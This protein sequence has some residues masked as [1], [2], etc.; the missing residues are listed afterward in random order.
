MKLSCLQ[1]NLSRGL[2]IV[3]RA[4]A[5]RTTLPITNNVYL[6][7]E[8]GRLKLAATNLEIA[9]VHW[10]GAKI[11]KEGAITVPARLLT[12][13]VN[14]LPNDKVEMDLS[15]KSKS[16]QLKCAKFEARFSGMDAEDFPPIPTIDQ[17]VTMKI[18]AEHLRTAIGRV[19]FAAATEDSRPV[20]TGVNLE[21][22][23][24]MLTLAAADG[25]RLSVDKTKVSTPVK[26]KLSVIVPAR[27]LNEVGKLIA[28]AKDPVT[29]TVNAAKSQILFSMEN[30]RLVSQ[31]IQ[32]AFPNYSQLIPQKH[33]TRVT[34]DLEE[35]LRATKAAS[36]FARDASGIVRLHM[37]PKDGA[38]GEG[39][40]AV[41]ARAEEVGDNVGEIEAHIGGPE[42]KIAFNAKYLTDVLNV[43][44]KG[45][46]LLD[47]TNASSPGLFHLSGAK[48]ANYKHVVMP[49]FVQW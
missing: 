5:T 17:G 27:A 40:V 1:E 43:I 42:A 9:I 28:E 38:D 39:K 29:V 32:G 37:T 45:E 36:I 23:G 34:V 4:V 14:S 15:G 22:E 11:E 24:D 10:V 7:T 20:L 18:E 19:V 49:M 3:G 33:S 48:D 44:G 26:E 2:A 41:S 47:V 13:F 46:L 21:V 6:A 12:D 8:N 31:L 16:L 30:V 25:F 35:F